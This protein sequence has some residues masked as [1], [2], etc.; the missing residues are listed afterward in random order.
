MTDKQQ[1]LKQQAIIEIIK[2]WQ[3]DHPDWTNV[4]AIRSK[5]LLY[6]VALAAIT[7]QNISEI[8][9]KLLERQSND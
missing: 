9:A 7:D 4:A 8:L 2:L 1:L 3:C 6:S 5:V